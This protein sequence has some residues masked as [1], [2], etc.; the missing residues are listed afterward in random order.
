MARCLGL[1][2]MVFFVMA[3]AAFCSG[4]DD[5]ARITPVELSARIAKGEMVVVVDV[6][7]SG[8]YERSAVKIRGAVRVS[9]NDLGKMSSGFAPD[10][11][12]VFYCT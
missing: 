12:L 1:A 8:S 5:V 9:L 10:S 6:R 7:S 11:A 2:V 4:V 3:S